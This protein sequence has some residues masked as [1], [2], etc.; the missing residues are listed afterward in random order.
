MIASAQRR[1]ARS[2]SMSKSTSKSGQTRP[3]SPPSGSSST[4]PQSRNFWELQDRVLSETETFWRNWFERRHQAVKSMQSLLTEAGSGG[5]PGSALP[6][7][8]MNWQSESAKRLM[9]DFHD[10]SVMCRNCASYVTDAEEAAG[11]AILKE[12]R[13]LQEAAN[14]E[15]HSTPV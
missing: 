6:W 10:W 4:F 9:Q 1:D 5:A 7:A 11:G 8:V 12:A 15:K 13:E 3:Q 2:T 14:P